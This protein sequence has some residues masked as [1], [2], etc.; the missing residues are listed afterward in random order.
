MLKFFLKR[1][2]L[3]IHE[4]HTEREA[5]TQA[6][7]EAGSMQGARHGTQ[8]W[9]SRIRPWTE[10]DTKPLSCP[11]SVFFREMSIHV[12]CPFLFLF[13]LR[14]YLFA[15]GTERERQ[16]EAEGEAGSMQGAQH[17]TQSWVS[18]I[19]PW[20]EGGPKPLSYPG[21]PFKKNK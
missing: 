21:C 19:T 14:F 3:F 11:L 6:E 5:E 7:E 4:R 18:R 15:R 16:T 12:F 10:G 17:G 13:F 8:S 20:A 2:Y 1:F 9:V